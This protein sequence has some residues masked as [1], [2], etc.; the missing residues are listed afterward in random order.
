MWYMVKHGCS[1]E[2]DS[3]PCDQCSRAEIR[4]NL[5]EQNIV[6]ELLQKFLD[7]QIIEEV[8]HE[9]GEVLSHIFLQSR[10]KHF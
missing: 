4:F 2:F 8:N 7:K 9:Q 10:D 3:S 5:E 6:Q 1:I